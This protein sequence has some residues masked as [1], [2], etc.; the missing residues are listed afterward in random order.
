[1]KND[2]VPLEKN[3]QLTTALSSHVHLCRLVVQISTD[4]AMDSWS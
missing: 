1:M 2:S 3:Q 4:D